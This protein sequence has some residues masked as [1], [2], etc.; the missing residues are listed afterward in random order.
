MLVP[1]LFTLGLGGLL[2]AVSRS[3]AVQPG[4]EV[5]VP[6]TSLAPGSVPPEVSAIGAGSVVMRVQTVTADTL[7]GPLVGYVVRE[8][9]T[10]QRVNF[11]AGA[12]AGWATVN[13]AAVTSVWRG[14]RM[15]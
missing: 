5:F 11:P 12:D 14:G 13:R 9:P 2:Y 10:I 3:D 6:V 15:L 4:D 1:V 8:I 7:S